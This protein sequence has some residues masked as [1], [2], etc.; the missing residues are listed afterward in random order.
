MELEQRHMATC[1]FH[2]S[3]KNT[4]FTPTCRQLGIYGFFGSHLMFDS[5]HICRIT[6]QVC[7]YTDGQMIQPETTKYR[8]CASFLC[9][10]LY[11]YNGEWKENSMKKNFSQCWT[12]FASTLVEHLEGVIVIIKCFIGWETYK[13][14]DQ[15]I[16]QTSKESSNYS[17]YSK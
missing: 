3:R 7:N 9:G 4:S 10:L 8:E 17:N 12:N 2:W 13:S 5:H 16:N 11:G 1:V 15:T 6:T 14:I